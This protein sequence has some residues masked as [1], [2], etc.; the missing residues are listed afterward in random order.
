[1]YVYP[2]ELNCDHIGLTTVTLWVV[3]VNGDSSYCQTDVT[4]YG[5]RAPNVVDDSTRTIENVPVVIDVVENDFDEK[6][7]IDIST[8][9]VTIKP[10][11]GKVTVDP[12]SGDFT[13]TPDLN[14]SGVDV[15]E[16][17]IYDDGI[18][19]E[20]E[21][22]KAFVYII[23]E[24]LN[25]KPVAVDDYYDAGCFSVVRNVVE[26]NDRD[27]DS[28]N[29]QIN[30]NPL[31]PPN[32]GE[33]IIDPDGTIN[34][35]P[36]EGFVG[37]DSFE[38]VVCDNGIPSLCDTAKV[39]INVDC[40]EESQESLE[41]ELFIPEGFSPNGDGIHDFFRIMCINNY[42]DAKLMIFNRNG[43]LLWEKEHYGNYD[44]WGDQNNAWWWGT[45][46]LNKYD[47][48]KQ[49]INGEPKLKVGNYV[50][51]LQLG[52]REVKNGTVMIS[53]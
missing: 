47:V 13:Y 17:R 20:P 4:I 44:V 25:D 28:D 53:Y 42:P 36:N 39:Y 11:H 27:P 50:Y 45:S 26:D 19:C 30:T 31:T 35:F 12:V 7:S 24:P 21:F 43:N 2:H 29:L 3:G 38:Y 23:V 16:Y 8:L 9:A 14:F 22:G 33:L 37:I 6:T 41:C 48:G 15:L 34:Y 51:V 10:L 1:M 46:V 5:N 32:H 40:N 52:N 18:P 49:M